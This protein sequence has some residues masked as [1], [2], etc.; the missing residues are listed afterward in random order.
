[1]ALQLRVMMHLDPK[2]PIPC[3][4]HVGLQL[5]SVPEVTRERMCDMACLTQ[6]TD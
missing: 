5:Q 6:S 2:L 1:M 4:S 3:I